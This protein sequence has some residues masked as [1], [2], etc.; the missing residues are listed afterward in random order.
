MVYTE[1]EKL[2]FLQ[3]YVKCGHNKR[4]A[5]QEYIR[6]YPGADIPS[7]NTFRNVFK[8]ISSRKD[9]HRK[10]KYCPILEDEHLAVLLYFQGNLFEM[11]YFNF[12]F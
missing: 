9:L 8:Q 1:T 10:T 5:R 12:F 6:R 3:I 11:H 7:A 2:V 4:E